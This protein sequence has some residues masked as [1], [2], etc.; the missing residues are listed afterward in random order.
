MSDYEIEC[1]ECGWSGRREELHCSDEDDNSEK[2]V[3]DIAFN[4]C[5]DCGEKDCFEDLEAE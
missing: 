3:D 4:C 2:K 1:I 5:P